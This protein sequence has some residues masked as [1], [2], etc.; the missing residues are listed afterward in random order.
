MF[1][2]ALLVGL[3]AAAPALAQ[4]SAPCV[5]RSDFLDHLSTNYDEAPVAMGLTAGGR[6]LEVVASD[7]GSWTIIVT[8]P[9]GVSCGLAAGQG[10]E[11]VSPPARV[12]DE[13]PSA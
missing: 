6:V 10:W 7:D 3:L 1:R 8:M 5:K 11:T 2:V 12:H 9:N 13:G 4:Q